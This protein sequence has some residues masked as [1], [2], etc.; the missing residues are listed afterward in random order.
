VQNVPIRLTGFLL[1]EDDNEKDFY[2]DY[3]G[4]PFL[5]TGK[6]QASAHGE[7]LRVGTNKIKI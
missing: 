1:R 3:E 7:E 6:I 2:V 4:S 5:E